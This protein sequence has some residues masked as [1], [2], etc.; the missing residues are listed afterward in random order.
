MKREVLSF[1][2]HARLLTMLGEQLIKN[3]RI[4]LVELVRNSYDADADRVNVR[5]EDFNENMTPNERSCIV[6]VDDGVGMPIQTL[7]NE[8]M[9]PATP[10]KHLAKK[11]GRG[12]TPAKGRIMQGEKGIGRFA[13]L[14]LGRQIA[15]ATRQS[16]DDLESVLTWDF[17]RFDEEF[18]SEA[19]ER[20]E[21]FLDEIRVDVRRA[22]PD[23]LA[24]MDHGTIIEIRNLKGTWG[25]P[26][27]RALGR[28]LFSLTDPVSRITG[29]AAVDPLQITVFCNGERQPSVDEQSAEEL[30]TLIEDKAVL[31]I[32]GRFDS[33]E[34][35]LPDG[36]REVH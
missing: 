24:D 10:T 6:V 15:I 20:K 17:S 21:I 22:E 30:R 18:V 35:R 3:E 2:P 33:S 34:E 1:R 7:R 26:A 11:D 29:R 19:G 12:A 16:G 13:V 14:K 8:W 27:I 25:I 32:H 31:K 9:N 36:S 5:F 23:R 28:E 4:A